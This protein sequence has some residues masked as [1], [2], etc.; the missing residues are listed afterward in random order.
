MLITL[1]AVQSV[2][3]FRA[4]TKIF[5]AQKPQILIIFVYS[6]AN[7]T[8]YLSV[9]EIM[10]GFVAAGFSEG[11]PPP[12]CKNIVQFAFLFKVEGQRL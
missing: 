5:L 6:E 11:P 1:S 3:L 2:T 10:S 12:F 9:L 4:N 7:L 8:Y